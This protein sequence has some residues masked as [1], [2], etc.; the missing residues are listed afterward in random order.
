M[1][2]VKVMRPS[3]VSPWKAVTSARALVLACIAGI[4]ACGASPEPDAAMA[5]TEPAANAEPP[6]SCESAG[7]IC[8]GLI[9]DD[10]NGCPDGRKLLDPKN[11]SS[12][13]SSSGLVTG[14]VC[15][16]PDGNPVDTGPP[17]TPDA[18]DTGPPK[19]P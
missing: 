17:K 3:S 10:S 13:H 4:C 2:E 19:A 1:I 14:Q 11:T 12:C 9:M 16:V 18:V 5:G 15:C 8:T 6:T 7:G